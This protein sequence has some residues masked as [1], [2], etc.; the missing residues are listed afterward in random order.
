M[1]PRTRFWIALIRSDSS[2]TMKSRRRL[3]LI[4]DSFVWPSTSRMKPNSSPP[5]RWSAA[6]RVWHSS[7]SN[8]SGSQSAG[9]GKLAPAAPPGGGRRRRRLEHCFPVASIRR[10]RNR[11]NDAQRRVEQQPEAAHFNGRDVAAGIGRDGAVKPADG[12][13]E[14]PEEAYARQVFPHPAALGIGRIEADAEEAGARVVE[15][16]TMDLQPREAPPARR[17]RRPNPKKHSTT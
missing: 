16:R 10:E 12:V 1:R 13:I 3:C 7:G 15:Q 8:A 5:W 14:I 6:I 4:V 11:C 9:P 2:W 17:D